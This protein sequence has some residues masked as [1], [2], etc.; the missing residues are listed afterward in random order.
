LWGIESG[1]GMLGS[2]CR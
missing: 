1:I 2:I